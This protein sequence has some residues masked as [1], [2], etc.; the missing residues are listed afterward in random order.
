MHGQ[1]IQAYYE[2]LAAC[3]RDLSLSNSIN[4][5]NSINPV[6]Q[7]MLSKDRRASVKLTNIAIR[8]GGSLVKWDTDR[9]ICSQVG[10]PAGF[11]LYPHEVQI[12]TAVLSPDWMMMDL[13][14]IEAA[15]VA[16]TS[17]VSPADVLP[18]I[19]CGDCSIMEYQYHAKER[20]GM[21]KSL[22]E[23]KKLPADHPGMCYQGYAA[24]TVALWNINIMPR[25][26]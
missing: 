5:D 15:V 21:M 4:S 20:L 2:I 24:G 10:L 18:G 16:I 25:S 26:V 14:E 22:A 11:T 6:V 9:G 17:N 3:N 8:Q 19:R 1:R 12:L 7:A 13:A 23:K